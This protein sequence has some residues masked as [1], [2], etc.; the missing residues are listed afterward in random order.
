[1]QIRE[2]KKCLER[3]LIPFAVELEITRAKPGEYDSKGRWLGQHTEKITLNANVQPMGPKDLLR[4][5]ENWRSRAPL[6][7]FT[8]KPLVLASVED[9][10]ISDSFV[11]GGDEYEIQSIEN[12]SQFG[13]YRATALKRN[14]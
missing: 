9:S 1:M 5:P 7:V 13:F 12:W 6:L 8:T 3:A 10:T 2:A 14:R 4:L 11:W